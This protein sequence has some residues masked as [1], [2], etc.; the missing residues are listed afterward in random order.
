MV[1]NAARCILPGSG[2]WGQESLHHPMAVLTRLGWL[3][4]IMQGALAEI[5]PAVS[6]TWGW[7][8]QCGVLLQ[9]GRSLSRAW[10]NRKKVS[11]C[12]LFFISKNSCLPYGSANQT[13]LVSQSA[14]SSLPRK[15]SPN[16]SHF[17]PFSS[18]TYSRVLPG[19][20]HI[21]SHHRADLQMKMTNLSKDFIGRVD[22][23]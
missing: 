3:H 8:G 13:R 14:V 23:K 17:K 7:E 12:G 15:N 1:L 9:L 21:T 5:R 16:L 20:A 18:Y 19:Q 6:H 11:E 4:P 2:G 10:G 22:R